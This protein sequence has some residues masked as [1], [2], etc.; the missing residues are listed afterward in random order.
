MCF[1]V[2][3]L[4]YSRVLFKISNIY[5]TYILQVTTQMEL[6]PPPPPPPLPASFLV[7]DRDE[8]AKSQ[9]GIDADNLLILD[10]LKLWMGL[11]HAEDQKRIFLTSWMNTSTIL[12]QGP[13]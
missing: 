10:A 7:K 9:P 5:F 11:H 2:N 13:Q 4:L 12:Q 1:I 6:I 3:L 8:S